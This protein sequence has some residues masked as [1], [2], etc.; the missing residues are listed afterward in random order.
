MGSARQ[1]NELTIIY[2]EEK[3]QTDNTFDPIYAI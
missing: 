2:P 1:E 3:T